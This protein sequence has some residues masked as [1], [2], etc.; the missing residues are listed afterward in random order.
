MI[1]KI[2]YKIK[3]IDRR[4]I[5]IGIGSGILGDIFGIKIGIALC[6][7]FIAFLKEK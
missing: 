7:I 1:K 4:Y 6:L 5:L 3:N 2:I